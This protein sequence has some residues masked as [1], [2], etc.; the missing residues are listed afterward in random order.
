[1][2][3]PKL[4]AFADGTP[5]P[6]HWEKRVLTCYLRMMGLTQPEA[7]KAVGR[8][9]RTVRTWESETVTWTQARTEAEARWLRELTDEAR[10][11]LLAAIKQGAGDL[12]LR[13]LERTVQGLAPPT[14][15]LQHHHEVGIGLSALLTAFEDD[16][17]D[18]N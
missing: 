17:A 5:V 16:D 7:G 14:Q 18:V 1:M 2:T 9:A 12:A 6:R 3:A 11:T 15:R 8:A 10:V 4:A 13:V